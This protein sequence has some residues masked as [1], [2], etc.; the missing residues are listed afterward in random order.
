V[1]AVLAIQSISPLSRWLGL[2]HLIAVV[3][4]FG[5]VLVYPTL[6][7]A[8][9]TAALAR[10]HMRVTLPALVA[11]WVF[12]M[13][14]AGVSKPDE[15]DELVFHMS[16]TWLVLALIDWAVLVAVAW[17]LIRPAIDDRGDAAAAKFSAGVGVMH[18]GLV[19]GLVLMIWKPGA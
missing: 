2:L 13:G 18:L 12:G 3:A 15:S 11:L 16:E 14:L 1:P 5:P 17:F 9:D 10:L 19:I 4:A 8:G 7:R 6:R